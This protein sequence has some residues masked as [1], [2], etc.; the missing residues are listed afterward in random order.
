MTQKEEV[1][2]LIDSIIACDKVIKGVLV[3]INNMPDYQPIS[4]MAEDQNWHNR[5]IKQLARELKAGRV[6]Y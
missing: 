4:S 2:N 6:T 5:H 3:D 1:I